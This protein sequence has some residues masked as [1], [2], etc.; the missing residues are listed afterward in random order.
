MPA[1]IIAR[2]AV[3]D[4]DQYRQYTKA[5][6][7][8]IARYGGKFIVRGGE[9]V[10]LEGEPENRR[11]VVIEFPTLERAKEFFHSPEYTQVK[12][13]RAGAAV[14]QFLAIDGFSGS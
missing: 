13:L 14:G 3:T 2:V 10:T 4:W 12:A 8:A 1:Y 7:A 11:L 6:P 9:I 5:T